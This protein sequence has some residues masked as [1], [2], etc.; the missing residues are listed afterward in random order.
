MESVAWG[1]I[2]KEKQRHRVEKIY[3]A[4]A[5]QQKT[6]LTRDGKK[7]AAY[8]LPGSGYEVWIRPYTS[9]S[10][11]FEQIFIRNEYQCI[12]EIYQQFFPKPAEIIIDCG[13]NIGLASIGFF[14]PIQAQHL[15][16]LSHSGK[17]PIW[18][19]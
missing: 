17:M 13:T 9:D 16:L 14:F 11:T 12:V 18:L 3:E 5:L 19:K 2:A 4:L 8:S 10:K 6:K 1:A 7:Y 15:Q